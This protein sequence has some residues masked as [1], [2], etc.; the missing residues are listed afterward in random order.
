MKMKK[1]L[2]CLMATMM[3][4]GAMVACGGNTEG[5]STSSVA[6]AAD[7]SPAAADSSSEAEPETEAETETENEDADSKADDDSA[8]EAA[9]AEAEFEEAIDAKDGQAYLAIV[10]GQW[11]VQYW[12]SSTADGYMLSYDAG[13]ADITGNGT[14]TVSVNADTNGFRYDTTGDVNGEYTPEG[15]SFLSVMIPNGEELYPDIVLTIDSITVDGKELEL[16]AKNYT[17]SDD[18][19]ETRTNIYNSYVSEPSQDARTAEGALYDE[20]GNALDICADYSAQIVDPA[21]FSQWTKV[22]VTFTVSGMDTDAVPADDADADNSADD[23]DSADDT[24]AD[25]ADSADDAS[26]D[27]ADADSADSAEEETEDVDFVIE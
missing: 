27:D 4:A 26:A 10:D 24:S 2:A 16:S 13:V 11:W 14:Y 8:V 1:Y 18:G 22:E 3:M 19:K 15:L 7:N 25:D 23:A 12:G 17:S 20:D 5:G 21:D 6:P 9:P